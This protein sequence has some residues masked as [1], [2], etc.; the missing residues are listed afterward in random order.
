MMGIDQFHGQCQLFYKTGGGLHR[1]PFFGNIGMGCR[2]IAD[3]SR[4]QDLRQRIDIHISR[5]F[6]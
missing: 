6:F 4:P 3:R 5:R 1:L 2:L